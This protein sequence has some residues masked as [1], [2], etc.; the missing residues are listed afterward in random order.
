M[1]LG[2]D[3]RIHLAFDKGGFIDCGPI[4]DKITVNDGRTPVNYGYLLGVINGEEGDNAEYVDALVISN[5]VYE[6]GDSIMCVPFAMFTR[7]DGDTKVLV[8]DGTIIAAE[9]A[10]LSADQQQLLR[11]FYGTNSP[12]V[13]VESSQV[14]A[15]YLHSCPKDSTL[16]F[17]FNHEIG[18]DRDNSG[19]WGPK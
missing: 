8:S 12:I 11:D 10:D 13:S 14:T 6:T 9:F 18:I 17:L 19:R 1:P 5:K 16:K 2:C 3:R 4:S 15:E 7:Q